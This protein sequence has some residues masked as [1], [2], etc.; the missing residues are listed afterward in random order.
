[1]NT[2]GNLEERLTALEREV[3]ALK[4]RV[5][6]GARDWPDRL[7][8]RMREIPEEDFETFVRLGQDFRD[9]QTDP[10]Y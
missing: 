4:R 7:F 6:D 8:G 3:A 1:M 9:S 10:E 5:G 2:N